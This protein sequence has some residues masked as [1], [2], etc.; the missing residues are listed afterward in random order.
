MRLEWLS[1]GVGQTWRAE[2]YTQSDVVH[3]LEIN[4]KTKKA[5]FHSL[6]SRMLEA[7]M[8]T[9]VMTS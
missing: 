5:S 1:F 9:K 8:L 3:S 4:W 7:V 6:G 2:A